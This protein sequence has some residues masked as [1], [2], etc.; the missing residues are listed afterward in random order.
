MQ[1]RGKKR[2][3]GMSAMRKR[4]ERGRTNEDKREVEDK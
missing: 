4:G 3:D 1:A 2:K